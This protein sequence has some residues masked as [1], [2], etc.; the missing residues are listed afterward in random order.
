M[1]QN[2]H[3]ICVRY[4][5]ILKAM[6]D[7]SPLWGEMWTSICVSAQS[8]V[9]C[10]LSG[11][12]PLVVSSKIP[13]CFP[14]DG[15]WVE[16]GM[17][18]FGPLCL[19]W[20]VWHHRCHAFPHSTHPLASCPTHLPAWAAQVLLL[21]HWPIW[22]GATFEWAATG[23]A[24]ERQSLLLLGLAGHVRRRTQEACASKWVEQLAREW[25]EVI[26]GACGAMCMN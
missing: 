4:T 25:G 7:I 20:Y 16:T 22:A 8:N 21:G 18:Q 17:N 12:W 23:R 9:W 24:G 1:G 15:S 13:V 26:C 10:L 5:K 3:K 11:W 2:V 19:D 14:S 6:Q